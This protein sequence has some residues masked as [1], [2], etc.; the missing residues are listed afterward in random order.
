MK[1]PEAFPKKN[2]IIL[3]AASLFVQLGSAMTVS[4]VPLYAQDLGAALTT[5]GLIATLRS[6]GGMALNLPGGLLAER[7]DVSKIMVSCLVAI[8]AAV[9]VRASIPS[10]QSLIFTGFILG[11]GRSLWLIGRLTYIRK[12]IRS[13]VRGRVLAGFGGM[14]RLARIIGPLIG[15]AVI[16]H[17]GYQ[18]LF[19][20]EASMVIVGIVLLTAFFRIPHPYEQQGAKDSLMVVKDHFAQNRGNITSAVIGIFGLTVLRA[21]RM[22]I[23]PLWASH[24]GLL[25]TQIGLLISISALFEICLVIPAGLSVDKLGRKLTLLITIVISAAGLFLLPQTHSFSGI[26]AASLLI[27]LGNGLGSG[28]NMIFS[29]DLAPDRSVGLFIGIWRLFVSSGMAAGPFLVGVISDT[30]SIST[31]SP[32]ISLVGMVSGFVV[33]VC[34]KEHFKG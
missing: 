17:W 12:N 27:S 13:Q 30:F 31:A 32:V 5:V 25:I 28:I 4:Y 10:L 16:A 19:F 21:A 11:A 8:A 23:I 24:N 33:L 7:H 22:L 26:L 14:I 9:L 1:P 18:H 34:F 29:T 2:I 20:L 6:L 15:S 3:Y